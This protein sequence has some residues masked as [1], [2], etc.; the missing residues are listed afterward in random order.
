MEQQP[1]R[2]P[3]T[4]MFVAAFLVLVGVGLLTSRN[5]MQQRWDNLTMQ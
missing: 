2:V 4:F 3:F 5:V 1:K